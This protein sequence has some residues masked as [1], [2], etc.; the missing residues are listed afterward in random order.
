MR[1]VDNGERARV[2]DFLYDPD[3]CLIYCL[4]NGFQVD[5]GVMWNLE[6]WGRMVNSFELV[7]YDETTMTKGTQLQKFQ[8]LAPAIKDSPLT[9]DDDRSFWV[10][11]EVQL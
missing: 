3:R 4:N 10:L 11:S 6:M 1:V 5:E 2:K 9:G 8:K 7:P